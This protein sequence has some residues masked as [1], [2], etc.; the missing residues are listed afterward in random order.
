M[1]WNGTVTCRFCGERGHNKRTCPA[2]TERLKGYAQNEVDGGEGRDGYWHKQYAKRTGTWVDGT[3][4]KE[5]KKGRRD[6]GQQRRC[7]FCGK[8]GHNRRSCP[9]FA[10]AIN[11]YVEKLFDFRKGIL[12]DMKERGLGVGA[13]LMQERWS[14]KHLVLLHQTRW[15]Q[16]THHM[17][18]ADIFVGVNPKNGRN[19]STGYPE[20]DYNANSYHRVNCV[21]PVD[22]AGIQ[23]PA[24]WLDRK[25]AEK[26]AKEHLKEAKSES[27]WD[28]R[29]A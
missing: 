14:E 11:D 1:S 17:G 27:W 28:N 3:P 13:L 12:A 21:G 18:N 19:C 10:T 16:I 23:A 7:T 5:M 29:Y 25:P 8:R 4:A 15:D 20:G 26:L 22:G 24:D 9:E 2:Y 6:A